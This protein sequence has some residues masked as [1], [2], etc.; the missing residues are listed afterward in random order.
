M[1]RITEK[2]ITLSDGTRL[3]KG[4]FTMVGIDNMN[5]ESIFKDPFK[6]KGD[7]FLKM[8]QQP[9]QENRWHF[10]STSPEHLVFGH[11]KH[12][13]P[14]RFFAANEIKVVMIYLLMKYDWKFTSEGKKEDESF[15]QDLQTDPT[16]KAMIRK[17]ETGLML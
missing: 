15:G 14:G 8:R 13:C 1:H 16:A 4:A 12:A 9:G 3:P 11:G 17:R 10:V 2:Q 6:F 5:D 7:R